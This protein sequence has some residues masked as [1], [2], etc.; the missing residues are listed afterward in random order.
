MRIWFTSDQSRRHP[1]INLPQNKNAK[2]N[3]FRINCKSKDRLKI[4]SNFFR[5]R[6]TLDNGSCQNN[7][8]FDSVISV[9]NNKQI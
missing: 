8:N 7:A 5:K 3:A 2:I 9:K 1:K 6:E 4:R